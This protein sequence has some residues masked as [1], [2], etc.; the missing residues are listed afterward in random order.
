M[1][2]HVIQ[3]NRSSSD[4]SSGILETFSYCEP[5]VEI[6]YP[7]GIMIGVNLEIAIIFLCAVALHILHTLTT[8]NAAAYFV[9]SEERQIKNEGDNLRK[10]STYDADE[11]SSHREQWFRKQ[12]ISRW[13]ENVPYLTIEQWSSLPFRKRN[14]HRIKGAITQQTNIDWK[15]NQKKTKQMSKSNAAFSQHTRNI[16]SVIK[17]TYKSADQMDIPIYPVSKYEINEKSFVFFSYLH[18]TLCLDYA[19]R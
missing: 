13:L 10:N 2:K 18:L 9:G 8:Q 4:K 19:T 17:F 7:N 16:S 5:S 6:Q 12:R 14:V 1:F 15:I 11:F 3:L